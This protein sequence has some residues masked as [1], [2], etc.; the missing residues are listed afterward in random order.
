MMIIYSKSYNGCYNIYIY[1]YSYNRI[2][3]V[4]AFP[5]YRHNNYDNY[6]KNDNHFLFT[7]IVQARRV[8]KW[9]GAF[10]GSKPHRDFIRKSR[11]WS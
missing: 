10:R 7:V 1:I 5:R 4:S 11:R 8:H 9:R 2:A 6:N 3:R